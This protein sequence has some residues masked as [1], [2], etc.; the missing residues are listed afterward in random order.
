MTTLAIALS[1]IEEAQAAILSVVY[2]SINPIPMDIVTPL[3]ESYQHL[4]SATTII[5]AQQKF[6]GRGDNV[7]PFTGNKEQRRTLQ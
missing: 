6:I 5:Q 3:S 7:I 1:K 4:K 2:E